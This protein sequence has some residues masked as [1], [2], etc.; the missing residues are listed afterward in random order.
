MNTDAVHTELEARMSAVCRDKG[1][2]FT[3]KMEAL[4][5]VVLFEDAVEAHTR[6]DLAKTMERLRQEKDVSAVFRRV[7]KVLRVRGRG[8]GAWRWWWWSCGGCGRRPV[9]DGV[10]SDDELMAALM[11]AVLEK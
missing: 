10:V 6:G 8:R 9:Y 7:D 4:G 2:D 5:R 3:T 1:T 11:T